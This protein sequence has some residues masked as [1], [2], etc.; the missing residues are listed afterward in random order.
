MYY[1]RTSRKAD[2]PVQGLRSKARNEIKIGGT[3]LSDVALEPE[4]EPE[5]KFA[6]CWY[7]DLISGKVL[8]IDGG[9]VL[10]PDDQNWLEYGRKGREKNRYKWL[11]RIEKVGGELTAAEVAEHHEL[12]VRAKRRELS[13]IMK[14]DAM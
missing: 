2:L 5:R 12:V 4:P 11:Y 1:K 13:G 6:F 10:D 8:K 3:P 7:T 14:H 9:R